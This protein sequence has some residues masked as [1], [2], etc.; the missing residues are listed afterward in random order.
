MIFF[1][2]VCFIE[3]RM[4]CR[5][6][7]KQIKKNKK[8]QE[9]KHRSGVT[10]KIFMEITKLDFSSGMYCTTV[11]EYDCSENKNKGK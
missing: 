4:K 10:Q 1:L 8:Y 6:I 7:R 3:K 2:F 5:N 9:R 11:L